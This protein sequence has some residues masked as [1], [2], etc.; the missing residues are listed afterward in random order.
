MYQQLLYSLLLCTC[1]LKN[2]K[3][4]ISLRN[5]FDEVAKIILLTL[6][7]SALFFCH[8]MDEMGGTH[9]AYRRHWRYDSGLKDKHPQRLSRELN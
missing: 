8:F 1:V 9:K 2:N 7:H 5:A 3:K 4:S 6:N